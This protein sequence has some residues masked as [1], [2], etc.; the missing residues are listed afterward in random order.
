MA[1]HIINKNT[2]SHSN[3]DIHL[4][5]KVPFFYF[6]SYY[7]LEA[8]ASRDL[9]I[10][11]QSKYICAAKG[12]FSFFS[13]FKLLYIWRSK[14]KQGFGFFFFKLLYTWWSKLK[15]GFRH[16]N[17]IKEKKPKELKTPSKQ[18]VLFKSW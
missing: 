1:L 12:F 6:W 16:K 7:I 17:L 4:L 2:G 14:L 11:L 8:S 9:D 18:F 13:F 15:Q 10:N 3:Q 5:R